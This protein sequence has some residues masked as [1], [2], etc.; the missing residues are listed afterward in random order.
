[1]QYSEIKQIIK[2]M[3]N[4]GLAELSIEFPDGTKVSLKNSVEE[5]QIKN[6]PAK[7]IVY[8]DV[9][10]VEMNKEKEDLKTVTSPMVGTFY[11]KS[12]PN[13]DPFVEVRKLCK[14]R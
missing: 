3:E 8:N 14:K 6:I 10:K 9:P 5:K 13:A 1:M 12:A 4:S 2:D 7:E 11:A